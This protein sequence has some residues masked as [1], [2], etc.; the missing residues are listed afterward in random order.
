MAKIVSIKSE[1]Q[2]LRGLCHPSR[3]VSG[4]LL[5]ATDASYFYNEQSVEIY[6]AIRNKIKES[7]TPPNYRTL[8]NDPEISQEARE[9]FRQSSA[10]IQSMDEAKKA[11]EVLNKYRQI[12]C[13]YEMCVETSQR[14]E[15]GKL[16]IE[17]TIDDASDLINKARASR[18]ADIETLRFGKGN[19]AT[20]LVKDILYGENKDDLIPTGYKIYDEVNGGFP[21]GGLVTIGGST[22]AGKSIMAVDLAIKQANMGYRVVIIPLEMTQRELTARMIANVTS[23]DALLVTQNHKLSQQ[24]KDVANK[25]MV[26]WMKKVAK[27]GG[28]VY[29]YEPDRDITI[30]EIYAEIASYD[31]DVCIIDYI[32]LLAGAD[33][34][35]QWRQL[36][37]IARTAK[38]NAKNTNRVN[39]LLCQVDGEGKIRYSRAVSEHCVTGDTLIDTDKGLIRIDSLYPEAV[40]PS[41]KTL[42]GIKAKSETGYSDVESVHYNGIRQVYKVALSNGM[43]IKCTNMHRFRNLDRGNAQRVLWHRLKDLKVG[44]YIAIDNLPSKFG[45]DIS[46]FPSVEIPSNKR[47]IT[48]PSKI[49][50]NKEFGYIS[51]ALC[52]DG[53]TLSDIGFIASDEV[54]I[55]KYTNYWNKV[56][57]DNT[58]PYI[59]YTPNNVKIW[60]HRPSYASVHWFI[61]SIEGLYGNSK[62]KYIP[63][64]ILCSSQETVAEAIAGLIDTDAAVNTAGIRFT[65]NNRDQLRRLQL[66][67]KMFGICSWIHP[68]RFDLNIP[69]SVFDLIKKYIPIVSTKAKIINESLYKRQH[70]PKKLKVFP[71]LAIPELSRAKLN[72]LVNR[73]SY[74][75]QEETELLYKVCCKL[76]LIREKGSKIRIGNLYYGKSLNSAYDLMKNSKQASKIL[77]VLKEY[78]HNRFV[79]IV[80]IEKLGEE[81]VYDLTIKNTHSYVANGIVV[82]NSNNSWVFVATQETKEAGILKIDQQKARAGRA[83]P[84]TLKIDYSKMRISDMPQDSVDVAIGNIPEPVKNNFASDLE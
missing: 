22:G 20:A 23:T 38:I 9:F 36:G 67:L 44:D 53:Y 13:L 6:N 3:A 69:A 73:S 31:P 58:K 27:A 37:K 63:D 77:S 43:Q 32:S 11:V 45:K 70:N 78:E 84:F 64:F 72:D 18:R 74:K 42:T 33:S 29:I 40:C 30:D 76:N 21:R 52:G 62:T 47:F 61:K 35:D 54:I 80:S 75:M 25:K 19:N 68:I 81:K 24:E 26:A 41:T 28:A 16:N 7:G 34:D 71:R 50:L 59:Q 10:D 12:R 14:I 1:L 46:V 60:R 82:H 49:N 65:S 55:N 51:G 4:T 66:M 5:A 8:I 56:F 2:V 15:S 48:L 17:K 39:I 83:F 79:Q 57:K